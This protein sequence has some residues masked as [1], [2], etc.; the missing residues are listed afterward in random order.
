MEYAL[1][2]LPAGRYKIYRF[3]AGDCIEATED[4]YLRGKRGA[5]IE[6]GTHGWVLLESF[7]QAEGG[8]FNYTWQ[9]TDAGVLA[10]ALLLVGE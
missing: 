8:P 6:P 1:D 10:D 7:T 5:W 2:S 4:S 3:E 9:A